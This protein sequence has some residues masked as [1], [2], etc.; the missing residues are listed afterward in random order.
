MNWFALAALFFVLS[1]G[2]LLTIPAG[3]KGFF[4]SGQT[5]VAAA[6]VHALVFVLVVSCCKRFFLSAEGFANGNP[7]GDPDSGLALGKTPCPDGTVRISGA[8]RSTCLGGQY[9][10][11][12]KSCY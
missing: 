1:P 10:S 5:S 7:E 2:V 11:G 8:C 6:L 12:S 3:S 4:R 9:N